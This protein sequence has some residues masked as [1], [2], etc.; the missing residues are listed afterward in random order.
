LR[1]TTG[2]NP[3]TRRRHRGC[4]PR[5]HE[6]RLHPRPRPKGWLRSAAWPPAPR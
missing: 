4:R 2:R 3:R 6:C 5:R 1:T